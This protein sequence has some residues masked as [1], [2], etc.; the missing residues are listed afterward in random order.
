MHTMKI[1]KHKSLLL[2]VIIGAVVCFSG[3]FTHHLWTPDEPR[4]AEIGREMYVSGDLVVPKLGGEPFL[5][6]PPLY[7]WGMTVLYAIFGVSD[8]VARMTS[9]IAAL[10]VLIL[11]YDLTRRMASPGAALMAVLVH[12][13]TLGFFM[14][15]LACIVDSWL[16][17]FILLGYW[18]FA[19]A[20]FQSS[21]DGGGWKDKPSVFGIL[22]IYAAGGLAFMTKGPIALVLIGA[23]IA[24]FIAWKKRWRFLRSWAHLPG[25]VLL[26]GCCVWWP[27][28]LYA[29]GGRELLDRFLVDNLVNRI[30]TP[31]KGAF[32]GGH[33]N[34]L[35]YYL[36]SAPPMF[37]PW[38]IALP[39]AVFALVKKRLP[40]QWN[41]PALWFF[42]SVLPVVLVLLSLTTTKRQL[43]VL[44]VIALASVLI[45]VWLEG[46]K[47]GE[48]P[49]KID[50][51]TQIILLVL[52]ALTV[53]PAIVWSFTEKG[54][55]AGPWF[56][57]AGI[58]LG[59]VVFALV[60][61]CFFSWRKKET[62]V[63]YIT[64]A[65]LFIILINNIT[66]CHV[67]DI[68]KNLKPF[69]VE[70]EKTGA[71]ERPLVAFKIDE[72]TR[73]IIPFYTGRFL[74]HTPDVEVLRE[75]ISKRPDTRILLIKKELRHVPDDMKSRLKLLK[76]WG[77]GRGRVYHLYEIL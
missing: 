45:G 9:S 21:E 28:M 11:V 49:H 55:P 12:A 53:V 30:I 77:Y 8:G 13:T 35:W 59:V 74:V 50:R 20:M 4:V 51:V 44:P 76:K 60:V 42:L 41:R 36:Y 72:T 52:A 73:A 33:K 40:A 32:R 46:T 22:V 19:L 31:P 69:T 26:A 27:L 48:Q 16:A 70:L 6:K 63:L 17:L 7:W 29:K 1:D 24:V 14:K 75:K 5:E 39:A 62:R 67:T 37:L 71:F 66:I 47:G 61:K 34:P 54:S 18:G 15:N 38:L 56:I 43:Y 58:A 65:F 25:L 10:L 3:T 23:P 2:V 68:K 64:L 57:I